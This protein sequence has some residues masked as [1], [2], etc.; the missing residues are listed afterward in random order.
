MTD[1]PSNPA[2]Q[3]IWNDSAVGLTVQDGDPAAHSPKAMRILIDDGVDAYNS[4]LATYGHVDVTAPTGREVD[5][6][7]RIR[8]CLLAC[9]VPE[10]G[11]HR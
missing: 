9:G 10:L 8:G 1:T 2:Q 5:H 3:P 6:R 7:A 4:L 11:T